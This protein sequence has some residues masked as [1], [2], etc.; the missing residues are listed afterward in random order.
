M[1]NSALADIGI[2]PLYLMTELFGECRTLCARSIFIRGGFEGHGTVLM[3]YPEMSATVTYSK[4]TESVNPSVIEG[5]M[6]TLTI[7][8][9]SSPKEIT[10]HLRGESPIKLPTLFRE[11]NMSFE[12]EKF[13]RLAEGQGNYLSYLSVSEAVMRTVDKIYKSAR[14]PSPYTV[15]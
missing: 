10:L 9:I 4:I 11:N 7:D 14:F 5:E 13:I 1:N 6:G 3:E 15:Q 2:Y 12:I 8:K